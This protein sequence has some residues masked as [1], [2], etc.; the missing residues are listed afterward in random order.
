MTR[1]KRRIIFYSL[2]LVFLIAGPLIITY[3]IGYAF[4]FSTARFDQ[5]G[6]IFIKSPMPRLSVFLDGAFVK[7]TGLLAGSALLTDILPG[8]H[9]LRLEKSGFRSWSKTIVVAPAEVTELRTLLLAPYPVNAATSTAE[10]MS[11]AVEITPAPTEALTLDAR[12][13]IIAGRGLNSR[14]ILENVYSYAP[15]DDTIFFVDKNGFFA[16]YDIDGKI[17]SIA[18]PGFFLTSAPLRFIAGPKQK[19]LAIIDP[20]GGLFL[21]DIAA[22]T[23]SPIAGNIK[24]ISF[25]S[26]EE[27]L[28]L[29]HERS[30]SIFWLADNTRQ[31]FQK[32]GVIEE[33]ISRDWVIRSAHWLYKT[34]SHIIWRDRDGIFLTEIERRGGSDT[35]ELIAGAVDEI[36]T[37][38]SF[39]DS[40]FY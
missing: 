23:L 32:R 21:F 10:E 28:L 34:D 37:F 17:T 14:V 3:A 2:T 12:G 6:G 30:V 1:Q 25:D 27:K 26:D 4:N 18:R 15:I 31:P 9:L 39:P 20:S 8:M 40:L 36:A 13:R 22:E 19:F 5:T 24:N 29:T 33:I 7:E 35:T 38:P 11:A 16:R